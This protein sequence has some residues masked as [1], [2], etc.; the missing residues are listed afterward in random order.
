[1]RA[2]APRRMRSPALLPRMETPFGWMMEEFPALFNRL[3]SGWPIMERVEEY[4][5]RLGMEENEKEIVIRAE[6]PG[7][8]PAEVRV[9][10]LGEMLTIEAEHGT[11]PTTEGAATESREP[12][13]KGA[14]TTERAYAHVKREVT[15]PPGVEPERAEATFRN[16]V[17]EVH[18][19]RKPEAVG[20]R[21]ELK[22]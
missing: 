5:W 14:E 6:L 9:E 11:P 16:G 18:L 20:R 7:F 4:P 10:T 2:I 12:A 13:E 3:F 17:L 8:E 19:P 21:I 1:M 22:T 15:L